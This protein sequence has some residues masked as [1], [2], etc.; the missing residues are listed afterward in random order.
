M[1]Y[2]KILIMI[3]YYPGLRQTASTLAKETNLHVN[4]TAQ[5][6]ISPVTPSLQRKVCLAV[7]TWKMSAGIKRLEHFNTKNQV[8]K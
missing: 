2:N 6:S 4:K 7:L 5:R 1:E 3:L 8:T